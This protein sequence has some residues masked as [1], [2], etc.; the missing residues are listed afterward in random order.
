MNPFLSSDVRSLFPGARDKV[1]FNIAETCLIPQPTA[2]VAHAYVEAS[3]AGRGDKA[4][5]RESV[6]RCREGIANLLGAHADEVAITKNVSEAL[7]L[8]ASSLP[9]KAGDNV[10]FCPELEHPNNVFLWLNLRALK[11]I[12]LR[13]I[14]PVDGKIPIDALAAA[15]DERT[16][17]V[18]IPHVSF[19]PGF[20]TDVR[21]IAD[22]AHRH[23]SL[24]VVDAAQ[25]IGAIG[26]DVEDLGIDALGVATQKNLLGFYGV[27]FLY[28]RRALAESLIPS[29]VAR[30]GMDLGAEAGE[31]AR[32]AEHRLPYAPGAR[33]FD[34][35]NYNYLGAVAAEASLKVISSIGI[36]RIERHLRALA[37]RL[38]EGLLELDLP[39]AG[40]SPGP[41]L[42][43][44]VAVGHSGGGHHDTADDPA[45]NDLYQHLTANGVHLSIR[46][47]ILRMSLGLY[48]DVSDVDRTLDLVRSWAKTRPV[49]SYAS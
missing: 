35:G 24:V 16:T 11:G 20:V 39:V 17:L 31:T 43:H 32:S 49:R 25:S 2:D 14:E 26:C 47:G 13:T 18:T 27:G 12:E 44:I 40:G 29:H 1:Y 34:L 33:R 21:A 23:G 48:N 42:G 8:L 38:A 7:N 6:E 30:Y 15:M 36:D 45:M 46:K 37:A 10:V 4:A 9:W 41:H 22:A 19:S 28:V 5:H 3:L